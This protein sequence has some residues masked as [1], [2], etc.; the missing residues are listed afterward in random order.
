MTLAQKINFKAI[1]VLDVARELLGEENKERST[2]QEKHFPDHAGLFVNVNKNRWFSHGN[3]TG[4]DALNLVCLIKNCDDGTGIRWLKLHGHVP[5]S[6]GYTRQNG[7]GHLI[8]PAASRPKASIVATYDYTDE[9]GVLLFQV[10]RFQ[11]KDFRQRKPD[12]NGAWIWKGTERSVLYRLPELIE[13]VANEHPIF[14][15]EGEKG[16]GA[17]VKIGV[18]ATCSPGGALKWRD[19]Y[20]QFL[21]GA[22]VIILRQNPVGLW[23]LMCFCRWWLIPQM[24]SR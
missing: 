13:A 1:P 24:D 15:A 17:L 11:P 2:A 5:R 14:I 12:G 9:K 3:G 16:V 20:S 19:E 22:N 10:V 18:T 21:E 8:T 4:G 7:N 6:E 23:H